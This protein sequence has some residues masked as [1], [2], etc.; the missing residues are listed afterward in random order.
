LYNEEVR[1]INLGKLMQKQD[2]AFCRNRLA[3]SD[4]GYFKV[5]AGKCVK[6]LTGLV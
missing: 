3:A 2:L 6:H 5:S 1:Q 4:M